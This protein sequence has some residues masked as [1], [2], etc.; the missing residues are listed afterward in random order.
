M[1]EGQKISAQGSGQIQKYGTN[2]ADILRGATIV[3]AGLSQKSR[4]PI[5][6]SYTPPAIFVTTNTAE[7]LVR[8]LNHIQQ[9]HLQLGDSDE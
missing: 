4:R 9:D 1:G 7:R 6:R 2:R 8:K 3:F 5:P